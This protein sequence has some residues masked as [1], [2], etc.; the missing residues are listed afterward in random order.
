MTRHTQPRMTRPLRPTPVT[1]AS[2]LLRAGPPARSAPVLSPSRFIRSGRSLSP[3]LLGRQCRSVPSHVPCK[4]SR[5]GSRHLRAGHRLASRRAPA[6]LIPGSIANTRFR[7]HFDFNNDTSAVVH[8]RSS[9]RSP[10][11]ASRAPFPHRSPRSRHRFRSMWWFEASPRR[12]AP[13]GQTF[14]TCTA[15]LPELFLHKVP[16]AF[17]AHAIRENPQARSSVPTSLTV[18]PWSGE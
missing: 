12:A 5:P 8:L 10:P 14:M 17:V 6:R 18:Q 9:S 1:G 3:P 7:C 11:N 13:K 16:F 15:L 2:A 4:T